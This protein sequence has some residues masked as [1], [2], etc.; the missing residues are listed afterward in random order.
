MQL[1]VTNIRAEDPHGDEFG[2]EDST[3]A[4]HKIDNLAYT[5]WTEGPHVDRNQFPSPTTVEKGG[6]L[7]NS[8]T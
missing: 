7:C 2:P 4:R 1:V 8:R 6:N 5:S 3:S